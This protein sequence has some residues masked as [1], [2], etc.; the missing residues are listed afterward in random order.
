MNATRFSARKT[1]RRVT[2]PTKSTADH[3]SRK[4]RPDY[5]ILVL[6]TFLLGL[7]A[8][9]VYAISP[10]ITQAQG[11][12]ENFYSYRQL[13]AIALGVVAFLAASAVP[14]TM[15]KRL[16]WPIVGLAA[17]VAL[18]VRLF[19]DPI[20][21]AYRWLDIGGLSFQAAE[22]IK[23]AL[24]IWLAGYLVKQM[25]NN[26]ISD[27]KTLKTLGA[28]VVLIVLVVAG[29]QSDL[30]SAAVMLAIIGFMGFIAGLPLQKLLLVGAVIIALLAMA[31]LVSP[32]RRDRVATYLNP[33]ADCQNE[34][35]Q[36]CQALIT[37]GSGGLFGKGLGRSV[38]AYGYLPEAAND[39]IFAI[40]SEKFGFVGATVM[41]A[42][43][44]A[45]F[46]RIKY[47]AERAPNDYARLIV[48]GVLAWLSVQMIINVGAMLG[49]LPLKGIT[50]P[51]VSYGGT[52]I[53]F[54]MAAI[55]IVFGISRYTDLTNKTVS[56]REYGVEKQPIRSTKLQGKR[57]WSSV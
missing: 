54:V 35:Y 26:G 29:L 13:T 44:V 37:V 33:T 55:G 23:F 2:L 49:L 10:G 24:V 57:G 34:G 27:L 1:T 21:G 38:Q 4:H 30:G 11:L 46:R 47:I 14:L 20:N 42:A 56:K 6:I 18:V 12:S 39:S 51:F 16:A 32:Y 48:S 17:V 31:I 40:V 15:W 36:A 7:G 53:I 3:N 43:F 19:S 52:S 22:L 9:T 8:V 28:V 5:I 45:L 41:V 50:L 25:Q